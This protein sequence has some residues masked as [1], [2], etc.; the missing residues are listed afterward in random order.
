MPEASL[1]NV[2]LFKFGSLSVTVKRIIAWHNWLSAS[3]ALCRPTRARVAIDCPGQ[4]AIGTVDQAFPTRY[5]VRAPKVE[6]SVF[7]GLLA[8]AVEHGEN[9]DGADYHTTAVMNHLTFTKSSV[10][11][12]R[13]LASSRHERWPRGSKRCR[14]RCLKFQKTAKRKEKNRK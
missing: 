8:I 7:F 1:M 14:Q 2:R 5:S 13:R 3:G 9:R 4:L 12:C 10:Q 11:T 6:R